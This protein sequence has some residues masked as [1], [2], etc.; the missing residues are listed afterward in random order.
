MSDLLVIL[1][2][3]ASHD[4][5]RPGSDAPPLAAN[6]FHPAYDHT[7]QMFTGVDGLRDN[8]IAE[9]QR[10]RGLE[11]ILGEFAKSEDRNVRRHVFEIPVYL[12]VLLG[13]FSSGG[14]ACTYDTLITHIQRR[15]LSVTFVTLNYDTLLDKAIERKYATR[16]EA[17]DDFVKGVSVS[18]WNYIKL[19]GSVNWGYPLWENTTGIV[20]L[21][22]DYIP[23]Y[24]SELDYQ[25]E[26]V[27]RD[28]SRISLL[29]SERVLSAGKLLV[30]PAL[31][32]PT[33]QKNEII[34]PPEHVEV[35]RSALQS[36]PA[37]LVVGNQGLDS[38]LMG[39]LR[40]S[41][42]PGSSK[43]LQI[44]EPKH[45]MAVAVR[46]AEALQGRGFTPPKDRFG[47]RDFVE[48]EDA[49]R[50]MNEVASWSR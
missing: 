15:S 35:L 42:R 29:A 6:L 8:I 19:H 9:T 22:H 25:E 48:S 36:D 44:V 24:L 49:E 27:P 12:K 30:Y 46:F 4:G 5:L 26:D 10:D 33:D 13:Q 14:R 43:P 38:D 17:M 50:F 2:A 37:I 31:A 20:P 11:A 39:I 21:D 34:C 16:M 45:G 41:A 28:P 40:E 23:A 7:Q 3:G 18:G 1:G 32:I 47:F